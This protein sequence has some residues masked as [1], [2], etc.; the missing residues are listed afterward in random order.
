MPNLPIGP[1]GVG[2]YG[3]NSVAAAEPE[4]NQITRSLILQTA[5]TIIDRDGA[6][7]LSMRRLS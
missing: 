4:N 2:N 1:D 5:L 3:E 7:R 6:D